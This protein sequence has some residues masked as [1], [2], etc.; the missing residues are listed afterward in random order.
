M[1]TVQQ[2]ITAHQTFFK[3]AQFSPFFVDYY[4]KD[5]FKGFEHC[6]SEIK[7]MD[8]CAGLD[9]SLCVFYCGIGIVVGVSVLG[10]PF[11]DTFLLVKKR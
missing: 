3:V 9:I 7:F 1:T 2:N 5:L 4:V 8:I 6:N 11:V 10:L